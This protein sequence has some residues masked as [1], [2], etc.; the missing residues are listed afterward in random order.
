M[1]FFVGLEMNVIRLM[2][3]EK[4]F[5]VVFFSSLYIF[6]VIEWV[7][8]PARMFDYPWFFKAL[9]KSSGELYSNSSGSISIIFSI[10]PA[11]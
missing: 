10:N 11:C 3:S 4:E 9:I 7:A 2:R 5:S 6:L 1:L 8:P